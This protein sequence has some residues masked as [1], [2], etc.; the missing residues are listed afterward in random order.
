MLLYI[1]VTVF[2]LL[3]YFL[4]VKVVEE[5]TP[6]NQKHTQK[7]IDKRFWWLMLAALPMFL[8]IAIRHGYMGADTGMYQRYFKEMVTIPW[9]EVIGTKDFEPGFLIFEKLLT[10]VTTSPLIYQMI[11]TLI[12]MLTVVSFAN[13]LKAEQFSFLFFF[14]TMG[15]YTFMYTAL[16]QCLAMCICLFSYR[17]VE[18]RKIIKFAICIALAFT[19]H[20]SSILFA[21]AYF[22]YNRR[23]NILNGAIYVVAGVI[24]F[25][26]IEFFQ[27]WFNEQ[28]DYEYGIEATDTGYIFT[29]LVIII[30]VFAMVMIFNFKKHDKHTRGL[31]NLNYI[32]LLFWVLRIA[33]RVA[34][35]PSYYFLFFTAALLCY[36]VNAPRRAS[37]R[38]FYRL[39]V[40]GV[41]MGLFIY[42]MSTNFANLIPFLVYEGV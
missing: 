23:I 38:V 30:T 17:F 12:Y 40:Y 18:N 37:D 36:G 25:L 34:E 33:T 39:I 3:I 9:S 27:E 2:P 22:L 28:L 26:N 14:A 21:I 4:Y 16:R 41:M 5:V 42:R 35:R 11:Y 15:I 1:F 10:Y 32:A 13:R 8:L 31:M 7:Y 24:S 19:F 20:K 29:I 6:E